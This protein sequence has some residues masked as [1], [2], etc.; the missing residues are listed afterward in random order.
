MALRQLAL[1]LRPLDPQEIDHLALGHME[2]KT[3]FIIEFHAARFIA[4]LFDVRAEPTR[5]RR[6]NR[7][8]RQAKRIRFGPH[9]AKAREFSAALHPECVAETPDQLPY[10]YRRTSSLRPAAPHRDRSYV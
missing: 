4:A 2:T 7:R 1:A 6:Y 3:K 5:P 9:H 10:H 8:R